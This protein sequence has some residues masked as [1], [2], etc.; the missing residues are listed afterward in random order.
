MELGMSKLEYSRLPLVGGAIAALLR[1][2]LRSVTATWLK[3][4]AAKPKNGNASQLKQKPAL[5]PQQPSHAG[6]RQDA[7]NYALNGLVV[8]LKYVPEPSTYRSKAL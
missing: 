1:W 4:R 3:K 6:V 7:P 5:S 8:P 2:S